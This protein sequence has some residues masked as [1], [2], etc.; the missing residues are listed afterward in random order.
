MTP[1]LDPWDVLR[2]S[3]PDHVTVRDVTIHVGDH[4]RLHPGTRRDPMDHALAGRTGVVD[5]IELTTEGEPHVTVTLDDDPGRDLGARH[6]L[7][8][9]FFFRTDEIELLASDAAPR[10]ARRRVLVAGIGN[11]FFN[12]DGFGVA[13]A[14]RLAAEPR[15][16]GVTIVDFGIRGFDLLYALQEDYDA[17]IL[18]DVVAR[19]GAPGTLY[20]ID[21]ELDGSEG[22]GASAADAHGMDPLRVLQLARSVGK[23]PERLLVLGCEPASVAETTEPGASL[24]TLSAPVAAAVDIAVDRIT[25]LIIELLLPATT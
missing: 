7:G 6:Y 8:H 5:A 2:E 11:V 20:L 1:A 9:R 4:V 10:E 12:D 3:P 21:P 14:Q 24:C 13:V 22:I 17:A 25:S 15:Q 19:G 16:P 23:V 18:I